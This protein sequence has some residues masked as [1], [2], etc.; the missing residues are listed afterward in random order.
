MEIVAEF[1][2]S[3]LI[4]SQ[5]VILGFQVRKNLF[6]SVV[7]VITVVVI[8][9]IIICWMYFRAHNHQGCKSDFLRLYHQDFLIPGKS[10]LAEQALKLL[11]AL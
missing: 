3:A 1:P 9:I 10:V 8:I 11:P 2:S 5:K 4:T 7:V 6:N